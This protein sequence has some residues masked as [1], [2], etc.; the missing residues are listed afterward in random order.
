[1]TVVE[2]SATALNSGANW[3]RWEPHVHA[4]GTI[5]NDQFKGDWPSYLDA[6]ENAEPPIRAIA[7][8]DYYMLDTYRTVCKEKSKGRLPQCEMIFPNVELRLDVGTAKAWVNIHLLVSPEDDRHIDEL[9]RFLA[10]LSFRA[11]EDTF[12]CQ[13]QDLIRLGRAAKPETIAENAA[14]K[15]GA[16]HF[17]VSFEQLRQEY[18]SSAWAQKNILIAVA[19]GQG[20]GSSALQSGADQTL[21]RELERFAHIIF[22]SNPNQREFWLGR[23]GLDA[24]GVK[25]VYDHLKPCLH[26]SSSPKESHL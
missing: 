16:E 1:M 15:V 18:R 21:R 17:K 26:G 5:F 8:T 10:R 22:S 13:A 23:K 19:G 2:K 12:V 9:G 25:A 20:D 6:L 14:L 4:P 3:Q 7:V 11:Y 24:D